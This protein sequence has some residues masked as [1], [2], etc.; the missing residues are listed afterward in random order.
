MFLGRGHGNE[1]TCAGPRP[2]QCMKC[3]LDVSLPSRGARLTERSWQPRGD[4]SCNMQ[5]ASN[6]CD[7]VKRDA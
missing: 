1:R 5:A 3:Q 6:C 4:T 7:R 2:V